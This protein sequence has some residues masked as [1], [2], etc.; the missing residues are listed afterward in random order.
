VRPSYR[1]RGARVRGHRGNAAAAAPLDVRV[2]P[3]HGAYAEIADAVLQRMIDGGGTPHRRVGPGMPAPWRVYAPTDAMSFVRDVV[4]TARRADPGRFAGVAPDAI[5]AGVA[6]LSAAA[7]GQ[8]VGTLR[9]WYRRLLAKDAA[10]ETYIT[11]LN[12]HSVLRLLADPLG[13]DRNRATE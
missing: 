13:I 3:E 12:P 7:K 2:S 8:L 6:R 10:D 1:S 11:A 5:G 9:E 4:E